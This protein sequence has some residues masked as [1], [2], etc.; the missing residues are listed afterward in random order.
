[1]NF[2]EFA[3]QLRSLI[4]GVEIRQ[5]PSHSKQS[6]ARGSAPLSS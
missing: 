4:E 1:L 3:N 6:V 2:R 5:P